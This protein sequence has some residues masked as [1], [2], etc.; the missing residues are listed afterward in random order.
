MLLAGVHVAARVGG[1]AADGE[2]LAREAPAAAEAADLRERVAL[3]DD[4]LLVVAVGDEQELLPGVARERNVPRRSGRRN[5]AELTAD[6]HPFRVLRD[7]AFLDELAVLLKHLDAVAR[8]IADVYE[9]VLRDLDARDVAK[10]PRGRRARIVGTAARGGWL[11]PVRAPVP[12]VGAALRIE[13][14]DA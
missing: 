11:L 7:D 10:L 5:G 1:D 9:P 3:Q 8:A 2:E 4:H 13:Y 14:D 6:R 12:L